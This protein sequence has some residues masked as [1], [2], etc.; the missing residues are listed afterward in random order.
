MQL[1]CVLVD[2][3]SNFGLYDRVTMTVEITMIILTEAIFSKELWVMRFYQF[4]SGPVGSGKLMG[5]NSEQVRCLRCCLFYC[6]QS[7][8]LRCTSQRL[9]AEA[10]VQDVLY[11]PFGALF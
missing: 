4:Y 3:V 9:S 2:W 8:A 11:F 10:K 7:I 1:R 6:Q 5:N